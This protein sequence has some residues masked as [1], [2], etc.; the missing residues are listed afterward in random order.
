M[1]KLCII[2]PDFQCN[3]NAEKAGRGGRS[4]QMI[5][6]RSLEALETEEDLKRWRVS[7]AGPRR[8]SAIPSLMNCVARSLSIFLVL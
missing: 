1:L 4:D 6:T 7:Q 8:K 3:W 5:Q 2:V